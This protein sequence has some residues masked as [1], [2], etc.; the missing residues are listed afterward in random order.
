MNLVFLVY[1]SRSGSTLLSREIATRIPGI[2][3][4]P[5]IRFDALFGRSPR[6][7]RRARPER[8]AAL[9]D[10]GRVPRKLGLGPDAVRQ[11]A[12]RNRSPRALIEALL[13]EARRAG[14][15]RDAATAVIK[16]GLHLVVA[17]RLLADIPDARFLFIV[18][19][20]RAA[21]ASKLATDRPY[22]PGL[23]MAW[24]GA[25]AAAVQWRLYARRARALARSAPL[26][27]MT[28]ESLLD[29]H[30][31]AMLGVSEFL[32][33]RVGMA[34]GGYRIPEEE[35]GIHARV[36]AG[37]VDAG[38]ATA[39]RGALSPDDQAVIE[40][41]CGREMRRWGYAPELQTGVLRASRLLAAAALG[42]VARV[43][44]EYAARLFGRRRTGG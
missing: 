20:P 18:R 13:G 28:Y 32:G 33:S 4:T 21:I 22:H 19:D 39:W 36:L 38:R 17:R 41:V 44:R 30:A 25:L 15:G 12:A 35:R 31:E 29:R 11:L 6:W 10:A 26:H 40:I 14:G 23:K 43:S 8:V 16:S 1:D 7:W 3:V 24:A 27:A 9:L 5:E 2:H 37:G 42:T 34:E